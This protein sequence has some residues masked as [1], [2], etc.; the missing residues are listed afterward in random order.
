LGGIGPCRAGDSAFGASSREGLT[1]DVSPCAS[2]VRPD[3][4]S[5]R[6]PR[7]PYTLRVADLRVRWPGGEVLA[8]EDEFVLPR[9]RR[10]ALVG[11]D[12]VRA[13]ALAAVLLGFLDYEGTATLNG[14]QLGD[15]AGED[16]RSVIGLCA[17]DAR[18]FET[19]VADNV[20]LSRPDATDDQIANALRR[21]GV[22]RPPETRVAGAPASDPVRD[23][24]VSGFHRDGYER[25]R[26]ALARALR[27]Y[28]PILIVDESAAGHDEDAADLLAAA[29][30]R[31]LLF[32]T[33]RA[34]V[35]GAAPI[36][37]RF[38]EV[39]VLGGA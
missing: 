22:D 19:T 39:R 37:G 11:A 9:G 33:C 6:L 34:A 26:I 7:P 29:G 21:A 12:R 3:G 4:P 17:R 15:L 2:R 28:V 5:A 35:P 18:V 27:A 24:A 20:R 16:V 30:D 8:I 14:V 31:T 32:V 10:L 23:A 36:L 13:S 1:V 38:D 25:Q